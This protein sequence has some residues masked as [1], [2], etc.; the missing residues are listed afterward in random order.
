MDRD[1]DRNI[2]GIATEKSWEAIENC[3]SDSI[4]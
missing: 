1:K 4:T 2:D 3:D